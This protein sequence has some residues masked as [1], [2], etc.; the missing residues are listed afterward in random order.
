MSTITITT[1]QATTNIVVLS[2]KIFTT[3]A[4]GTTNTL[5][6]LQIYQHYQSYHVYHSYHSLLHSLPSYYQHSSTKKDFYYCCY[7]H[8]QHTIRLY[9]YYQIWGQYYTTISLECAIQ[10]LLMNPNA[11]S[12]KPVH[13]CSIQ[14]WVIPRRGAQKCI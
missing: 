3:T 4:M 11:L 6:A 5:P 8:Y 9:R 7:G 10:S 1:Y 2:R 12:L 14:G 13:M